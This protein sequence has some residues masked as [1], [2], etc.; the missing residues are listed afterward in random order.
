MR[1]RYNQVCR[2]GPE[3]K[4]TKEQVTLIIVILLVAVVTAL[5]PRGYLIVTESSSGP[6]CFG[7]GVVAAI[8][9]PCKVDT[10]LE[11]LRFEVCS[12]YRGLSLPRHRY[13]SPY[14]LLT[15]KNIIASSGGTRTQSPP[16]CSPSSSSRW[17]L[18]WATWPTAQVPVSRST[19]ADA[20]LGSGAVLYRSLLP[21]L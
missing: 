15:S 9:R 5:P 4:V 18:P 20:P 8:S 1:S 14:L 6:C 13:H 12:C 10:P 17:R 21:S 2:N 19:L 16:S 11:F 3:R 7:R